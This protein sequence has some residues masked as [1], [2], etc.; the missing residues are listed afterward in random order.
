VTL[1]GEGEH[2]IDST[3]PSRALSL[4]GDNLHK[5]IEEALDGKKLSRALDLEGKT[6][7][8]PRKQQVL[9]RTKRPSALR[10]PEPCAWEEDH[11]NA[12]DDNARACGATGVINHGNRHHARG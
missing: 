2:V 12:R 9:R 3:R 6:I 5:D 10:T 1:V 8:R 4:Q 7:H 11:V